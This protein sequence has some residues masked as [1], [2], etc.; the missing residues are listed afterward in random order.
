MLAPFY[1][2]IEFVNLTPKQAFVQDDKITCYNNTRIFA[3]P[4]DTNLGETGTWV[5]INNLGQVIES[6]NS[7][8]T[9]INNLPQGNSQYIWEISNDRCSTTDTITITN[10]TV[11]ADAGIDRVVCDSTAQLSANLTIGTG[12]WE[13]PSGNIVIEDSNSA[14]TVVSN[15]SFG[16]NYFNWT[17][18]NGLCEDTDYVVVRS[19]L[20][21]NVSAGFGSRTICED[22][23]IL[24]A[25]YPGTGTGLW[26]IVGCNGIFESPTSNQT[27]VSGLAIGE[28]RF[29]WTVTV[30]SCSESN[31]VTINNNQLNV[32]AGIDEGICNTDFLALNGTQ[33]AIGESGYWTAIGGVGTYFDNSSQ[34]NTTVRNLSQGTTTLIWTLTDGVCSNSARMQV[35]NNTPSQALVIPDIETCTD[36]A[37]IFAQAISFGTGIW[38]IKTGG[39]IISEPTNNST[40]ING[41]PTGINTYT[42]TVTNNGCSNSADLIVTNKSVNAIV[43]DNEIEICT[44]THS[45][46]IIGNALGIEET[47]IWSKTDVANTCAI[48]AK[49]NN[50]TDVINLPGGQTELIWTVRNG[51]CTNSDYVVITN[52]YHK[53]NFAATATLPNP[54]CQDFVTILGEPFPVN[55]TGLWSSTSPDV[56]FDQADIPATSVKNLPNG[57]TNITWTITKDGCS[58]PS[59]FD[60]INNEIHTSAG[61][62]QLVCSPETNL[63][64]QAL[65][66]G[67]TGYW[68]SVNS[69]VIITNSSDP[70]TQVSKLINGINRFTWTVSGNGCTASDHVDISNNGF[71]AYAGIDQTT[72]ETSYSLRASDPLSGNGLWTIVSGTG[73]F[74]NPAYSETLVEDLGNGSNTF[75]W[76]VTRH[77]CTASDEVTITNNFYAANAGADMEICSD[78]TILNAEAP[79]PVWG[80]T[81][82]WTVQT[83]EGVISAPSTENT[84][85]TNLSNGDNR[86]RW[87]IQKMENDVICRS[88]DEIIITNYSI[89]AS[90][91]TDQITCN[92][93]ITLSATPLSPTGVGLWTSESASLT[94]AEPNS[95]TTLVSNLQQGENIISWTV[96]DNGCTGTSMVEITSYN[97]SASAGIDQELTENTTTMTAQLPGTSATGTWSII[98]GKGIFVDTNNPVSIV[99]NLG[100]GYNT[101]RWTVDWNSCIDFDDI[102]II[103][104]NLVANAGADQEIYTSSTYLNAT[105][106]SPAGVGTWTITS[107][108]GTIVD[109]NNPSTEV[110]DIQNGSVNVYRWSVTGNGLHAYDEVIVTYLE[111]NRMEELAKNG[112][113]I[114]PNPSKG[115]FFIEFENLNELSNI[116]VTNINGQ[117]VLQKKITRNKEEIDLT[118]FGKGMYMLT[119]SGNSKLIRTKIIIL[120]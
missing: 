100:S 109:A 56:T 23:T 29:R 110:T 51:P 97:F 93:Y 33:P 36:N 9:N 52:N 75:R 44:P 27:T 46:T 119:I 18:T 91:G 30:N 16:N 48:V 99:N 54:L 83:G 17:V 73:R 66:A 37:L 72:C 107:G 24:A 15:L 11:V 26:T 53:H 86:L 78:Q 49:T 116:L 4:P 2:E 105:D 21:R 118:G 40:T 68:T 103:Y 13:Q 61:N 59:S 65:S 14:N 43:A 98:S 70:N 81:G 3:N 50:I 112:I 85:I 64:A 95:A 35:I 19:D 89:T 111:A 114:Y 8:Q 87:T 76:T 84:L 106:P 92:D 25:S 31:D 94:I 90:A 102:T 71:N 22:Y 104:D 7:Y 28:N 63:N 113:N 42:W 47:G 82:N 57:T 120:D 10:N 20:P 74:A 5:S 55:G 115:R 12:Y 96:T 1:D 41:I 117:N 108:G 45:A 77:G 58:S 101:F 79:N 69:L 38:T 6:P 39:G 32:T 62:D 34:Y 88:Y 80:V 60:L 67:E